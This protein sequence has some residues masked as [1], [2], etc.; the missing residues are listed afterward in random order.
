[1]GPG[2]EVRPWCDAGSVQGP[3]AVTSRPRPRAWL[4]PGRSLGIYS[5]TMSSP[6]GGRGHVSSA[7]GPP[8]RGGVGPGRAQGSGTWPP[9]G[10]SGGRPQ[11]QAGCFVKPA[12]LV[13]WG[14]PA[15]QPCRPR[16]AGNPEIPAAPPFTK[17]G[18]AG[19]N[20]LWPWGGSIGAADTAAST[21][22]RA[23]GVWP[24]TPNTK[25][26]TLRAC[27]ARVRPTG[28]VATEG[29]GLGVDTAAPAA[30]RSRWA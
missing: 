12:L 30:T 22:D 15:L 1:M 21:R 23:V 24:V 8:P 2:L 10:G 4:T 6:A 17:D 29:T 18:N 7:G 5:W 3:S 20:S 16:G 28:L 14:G 27:H 11:G 26:S 25:P 9:A 13:L 19:Q